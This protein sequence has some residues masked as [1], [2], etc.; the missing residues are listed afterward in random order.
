MQMSWNVKNTAL[1][2]CAIFVKILW[3]PPFLHLKHNSEHLYLFLKH[4]R[5]VSSNNPPYSLVFGLNWHHVTSWYLPLLLFCCNLVKVLIFNW[6]AWTTLVL[7]SLSSKKCTFYSVISSNYPAL[8]FHWHLI[9][10]I[11][12]YL[13]FRLLQLR[14]SPAFSDILCYTKGLE[15]I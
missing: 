7:T 14:L 6:L 11:L 9:L 5:L 15:V 12:H 1:I 10:Q 13:L 4:Q 2:L 3:T 8:V